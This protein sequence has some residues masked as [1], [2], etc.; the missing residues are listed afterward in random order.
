MRR[1]GED[2]RS[3]PPGVWGSRDAALVALGLNA[4]YLGV[5]TLGVA[6]IDVV[7]PSTGEALKRVDS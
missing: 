6:L 1:Y 4:V 5:L 2:V 7:D 3:K